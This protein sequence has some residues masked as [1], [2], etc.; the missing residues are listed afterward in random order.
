MRLAYHVGGGACCLRPCARPLHVY[1]LVKCYLEKK[2]AFPHLEKEEI[3]RYV[4]FD[5]I[6]YLEPS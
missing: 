2:I 4:E 6:P 3:I 5:R 1:L